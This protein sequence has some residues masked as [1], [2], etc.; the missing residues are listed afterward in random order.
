MQTRRC[1]AAASPQNPPRAVRL[2]YNKPAA[3]APEWAHCGGFAVWAESFC[4][5]FELLLGWL[6]GGD[7]DGVGHLY[8]FGDVVADVVFA[9]EVVYAGVFEG[10]AHV[11]AHTGEHHVDA[12]LL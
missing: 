3:V 5:R 9:D 4:S 7:G 10:L 12:F 8:C 2:Q 1:S 6:A 11:V